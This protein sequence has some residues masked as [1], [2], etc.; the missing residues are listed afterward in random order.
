MK[1]IYY[2]VEKQ[3]Q[4]IGEV[5][6]T[7]GYK[8]ITMYSVENGELVLF[9]DLEI[10]LGDNSEEAIDDYLIDNGYGDEVFEL[11]QL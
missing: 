4:S 2:V 5:E 8:T 1:R 10:I 3:L 9:G 11:K 7:T 6:E